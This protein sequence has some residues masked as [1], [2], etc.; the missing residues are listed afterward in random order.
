MLVLSR[1]LGQS[2]H[3]GEGVRITVVKIDNNSVRIGI[4]APTRFPSSGERSLLIRSVR[5]PGRIVEAE[6][7]ELAAR[8]SL[9]E[10]GIGPRYAGLCAW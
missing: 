5:S 2:F 4:D 10:R 1:K 6:L 8:A 3:V 9:M 7:A